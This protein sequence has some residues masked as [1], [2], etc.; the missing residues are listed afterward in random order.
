MLQVYAGNDDVELERQESSLL[1]DDH[2]PL[3]WYV[4]TTI[5][6]ACPV[7]ARLVRSTHR[8]VEHRNILPYADK[9]NDKLFGWR[10]MRATRLAIDRWIRDARV[11]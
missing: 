3:A 8:V 10:T 5:C 1:V 7:V 9:F 4:A 2:H 6:E 11:F